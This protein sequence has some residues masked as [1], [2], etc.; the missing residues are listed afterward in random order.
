MSEPA[1]PIRETILR[2]CLAAAPKPWYA[3]EYAAETGT[4]RESLYGPLNDLRLANLVELT[5]WIQG[6]GQGYAITPFGKEVLDDP[7][8]LAQLREGKATLGAAPEPE[9]AAAPTGVT[10]F[11]RGEAARRAF[12]E[13]GPIRVVPALIFVNV[14]MFLVS[15]AV[16]AQEGVGTGKFLGGGEPATLHKVGALSA[17]DLARGEWWRLLT[18]CFLHFGLLHLLM[19]MAALLVLSRVE[20]LWGSWRFLLLYLTCGL[21]GSCAGVY[22]RPGALTTMIVHAGA[23][24]AVWGVMTSEFGWL[25]I[26]RSHLPSA[27]VRRRLQYLTFPLLLNVGVSMTPNVSAAAHFGG[28]LIG[29][30]SA[31]L[32]QMHRYGPPAKRAIAGVQLTLLPMLFLV[33]L[34]VAMEYDSRLKPFAIEEYR[35]EAE[36]RLGKLAPTMDAIEPK[37]DKLLA[38]DTSKRDP[39][40]IGKVREELRSLVKKTKE[41]EEWLKQRSAGPA[42]PMREKGARIIETLIAYAEALDKQVGGE[43]VPNLDELRRNYHE[44]RA[45]WTKAVTK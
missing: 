37:A 7:V 18:S 19:N 10:R 42:R 3:K 22:F 15:V 35:R 30:V 24:G 8:F 34:A 41:A 36:D 27:E 20:A 6:K 16:A 12:Y 2:Q 38:Q 43:A 26:N 28:G 29:F 23:S 45:E 1:A 11:E 21:C 44:A 4:D 25:L 13:P 32:L 14:V 40:E 9:P 33:G 39:A 17:V 31:F 5:D